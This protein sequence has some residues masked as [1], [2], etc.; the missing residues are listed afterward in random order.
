MSGA[1]LSSRGRLLRKARVLLVAGVAWLLGALVVSETV[2][3]HID[4][5]LPAI[6]L[7]GGLLLDRFK[8]GQAATATAVSALLAILAAGLLLRSER[9]SLLYIAAP[10]LLLFVN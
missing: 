6:A 1:V 8:L 7:R 9:I 5:V 3:G 2:V 10:V 4:R